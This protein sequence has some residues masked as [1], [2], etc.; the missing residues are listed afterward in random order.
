[1]TSLE[2]ITAAGANPPQYPTSSM[3]RGEGV[4]STSLAWRGGRLMFSSHP[5]GASLTTRAVW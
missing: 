4:S 2:K 5:T 3:Y 1:M